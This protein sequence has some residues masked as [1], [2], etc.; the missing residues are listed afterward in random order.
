MDPRPQKDGLA[1]ITE[2]MKAIERRLKTLETP[3]GTQRVNLRDE[4]M[5]L[6]DDLAAQ[7]QDQIALNSMTSAAIHALVA[8]PPG[9]VTVAGILAAPTSAVTNWPS[10]GTAVWNKAGGANGELGL[11]PSIRAAKQDIVPAPVD[12]AAFRS[13][14]PVLFRYRTDVDERGNEARIDRGFIAEDL[15]A[16]GFTEALYYDGEGNLAGVNYDRLTPILW[17][18]NKQLLD[19][20]DDLNRR[21]TSLENGE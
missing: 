5:K 14:D 7:V 16:A 12:E 4:V 1:V 9:D 19:A 10:Y 18:V 17:E 21:L 11:I 20:H 6:F 3:S 2:T 15:E 13:I 8:N